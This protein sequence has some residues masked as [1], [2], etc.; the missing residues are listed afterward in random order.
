[1]FL[2]EVSN[3]ECEVKLEKAGYKVL[4]KKEQKDLGIGCEEKPEIKCVKDVL[5]SKMDSSLKGSYE[6]NKRGSRCYVYYASEEYSLTSN[7]GETL[8]HPKNNWIFFEN[9]SVSYIRSFK[10]IQIPNSLNPKEY[11]QAE[12]IG[13]WVCESG[14]ITITDLKYR[15]V[16]EFGE[17]KNLKTPDVFNIKKP[18]GE[19]SGVSVDHIIKPNGKIGVDYPI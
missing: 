3:E 10:S 17:Y 15:G 14:D 16:Y 6:I 1:M 7:S 11:V 2:N 8:K 12:Y 5:D 18:N 19:D 9:G 13:K 4:D